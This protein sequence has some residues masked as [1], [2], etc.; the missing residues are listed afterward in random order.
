MKR[1]FLGVF[2]V[3][4]IALFV[5]LGVW[6]LQRLAWKLDL[7]ETVETRLAA[8]PVDA[9]GPSLWPELSAANGAYRRVR[10][11]GHFTGARPAL[12]QAVTQL[13]PGFWV[14]EP[15]QTDRGFVVLVN[16]GFATKLE[17]DR[18]PGMLANRVTLTGLLRISEPGGAFLRS[19]DPA[20]DRWYS[21]DV[22]A[23]AKARGLDDVA[24]YF[25]DADASAISKAP[26]IGGLTV[27]RFRNHHLIYALTWFGLAATL[28]G[29]TVYLIRFRRGTDRE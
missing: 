15:F 29:W 1:V 8:E 4:G 12:V 2:V 11:S 5:S 23:I 13:G 6:Q 22:T 21:R 9:P 14:V 10:I 18:L 24:P 19:N 3:A 28:A 27:V 25:I 16:R 17:A 7:I 20:V 26:P